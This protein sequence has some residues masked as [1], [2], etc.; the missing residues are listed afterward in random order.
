MEE[1]YEKAIRLVREHL[2]NRMPTIIPQLD[3]TCRLVWFAKTLQNWKAIVV[4]NLPDNFMYEVIY[5]GDKKQAYIDMYQK[6]ENVCIP[7]EGI[8]PS[9]Q[10]TGG[11][12]YNVTINDDPYA[13]GSDPYARR[14]G[15]QIG[16]GN[17]QVNIH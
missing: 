14:R 15:F 17:T 7:D 4:T 2:E 3:F 1:Y 5:D 16:D 10:P 12:K 9:S 13:Y 8:Q 11:I 6:L